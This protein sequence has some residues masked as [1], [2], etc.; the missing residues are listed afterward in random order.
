MNWVAERSKWAGAYEPTEYDWNMALQRVAAQRRVSYADTL[1]RVIFDDIERGETDGS[2][3]MDGRAFRVPT[4]YPWYFVGGAGPCVMIPDWMVDQEKYVKA[5]VEMLRDKIAELEGMSNDQIFLG[6][7]LDG[8]RVYFDVSNGIGEYRSA[9]A[10]MATRQS[11]LAM[12][13]AMN[14]DSIYREDMDFS[15]QTYAGYHSKAYAE[16]NRSKMK[17]M[18]G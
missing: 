11:E 13:D 12:F 2:Y 9:V 3:M 8:G 5:T 14:M 15:T 18:L 4:S 10:T 16:W 1:A 6:T 17:S 7:W